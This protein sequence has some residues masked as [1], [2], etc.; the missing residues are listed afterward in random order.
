MS[1][2]VRIKLGNRPK[3]KREI[4]KYLVTRY[5]PG[6]VVAFRMSRTSKGKRTSAVYVGRANSMDPNEIVWLPESGLTSLLHEIG[7]H[8]LEGHGKPK[9]DMDEIV[10]EAL[11]WRWA[12]WAAQ[13]E[14]LWFD[15]TMA[16]RCFATYTKRAP[17]KIDWRRKDV[18]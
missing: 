3:V 17:L 12:E 10:N 11:A 8:R 13:Q 6:A 7:H 2:K 1:A 15:Y 4:A 18:F 5:A 14:N 16:D 9:S